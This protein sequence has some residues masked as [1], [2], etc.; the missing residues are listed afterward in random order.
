MSLCAICQRSKRCQTVW[1]VRSHFG[2]MEEEWVPNLSFLNESH[3]AVDAGDIATDDKSGGD[4]GGAT[5]EEDINV[6]LA[7]ALAPVTPDMCTA[8]TQKVPLGQAEQPA[9]LVP[10][11]P[12]KKHVEP[13]VSQHPSQQRQSLGCPS[14]A[15][16]A[17]MEEQVRLVTSEGNKQVI[18][19]DTW[20][21]QPA[22]PS[23]SA[24]AVASESENVAAAAMGAMVP[25]SPLQKHLPELQIRT[26][27][28]F[29]EDFDEFLN[30]PGKK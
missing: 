26:L 24:A 28:A 9:V 11:S 18:T 8:T 13:V 30:T 12:E 14:G 6:T 25:R 29:Q 21:M 17:A 16:A 15:P 2:T 7:R 1:G 5:D 10:P 19:P 23:S 3:V 4:D 20:S 27:A 22:P